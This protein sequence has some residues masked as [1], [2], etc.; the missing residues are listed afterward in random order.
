MSCIQNLTNRLRNPNCR[1]LPSS[2]EQF[3]FF[4]GETPICEK[5]SHIIGFFYLVSIFHLIREDN[6]ELHMI[7]ECVHLLLHL[8]Y[9]EETL[10]FSSSSKFTFQVGRKMKE[11]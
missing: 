11:S 2:R 6:C 5:K 4:D 10:S 9:A 3:F 8:L 1:V 7:N